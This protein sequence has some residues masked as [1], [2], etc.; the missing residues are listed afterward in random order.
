M[1]LSNSSGKNCGK[2]FNKLKEGI[3]PTF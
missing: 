2:Y 3:P 1:I